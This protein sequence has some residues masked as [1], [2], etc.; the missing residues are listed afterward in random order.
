MRPF[1]AVEPRIGLFVEP[2]YELVPDIGSLTALF[3]ESSMTL[4]DACDLQSVRDEEPK[5]PIP[6]AHPAE[7]DAGATAPG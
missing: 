6:E 2:D 3:A 5:D 7:A 4:A 1:R